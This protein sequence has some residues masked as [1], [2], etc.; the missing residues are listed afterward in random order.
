MVALDCVALKIPCP[1]CKADTDH[2]VLLNTPFPRF[3]F[4]DF[5]EDPRDYRG[6]VTTSGF[7]AT[8]TDDKTKQETE[9]GH[10]SRDDLVTDDPYF[11]EDQ[12]SERRDEIHHDTDRQRG[13][14]PLVFDQS[15]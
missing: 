6:Q 8:Y 5:S 7:K 1:G 12:T 3:R 14:L 13:T 11:G 9:L 2:E 10:C 4:N 15:G